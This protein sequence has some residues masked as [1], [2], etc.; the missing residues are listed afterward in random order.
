[1]NLN[2]KPTSERTEEELKMCYQQYILSKTVDGTYCP[3]PNLGYESDYEE[4][5]ENYR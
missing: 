5:D 2:H 1:M 4:N 3:T